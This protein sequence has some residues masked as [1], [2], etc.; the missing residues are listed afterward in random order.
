MFSSK[1]KL[2]LFYSYFQTKITIHDSK[3]IFITKSILFPLD[4]NSVLYSTIVLF[5]FLNKTLVLSTK[6]FFILDTFRSRE[7][8]LDD[9]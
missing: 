2:Y 7:P 8:K 3:I 1:Q 5:C 9:E 4:L 6:Y